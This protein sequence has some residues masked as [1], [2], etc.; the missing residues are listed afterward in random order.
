LY[1]Y[2]SPRDKA[3]VHAG[4][5]RVPHF[6]TRKLALWGGTV[7]SR[8]WRPPVPANRRC[9]YRGTSWRVRR[10]ARSCRRRADL[11]IDRRRTNQYSAATISASFYSRTGCCHEFKA[12][13]KTSLLPQMIP[14]PQTV[15][16]IKRL[17]RNSRRSG[18]SERNQ[19]PP[20]RN[21]TGGEQQR[22]ASRARGR[23]RAAA[24][25]AAEPTASR[26]EHGD[27]VFQE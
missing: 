6:S 11:A 1:G 24:L 15:Q 13:E 12:I 3:P 23:Q 18:L 14:R 22:V 9:A 21:R 8:W 2:L 25:L 7:V 4:K 17:H 19:A 5:C 10:A 27:H 20:L 16:T 26:P